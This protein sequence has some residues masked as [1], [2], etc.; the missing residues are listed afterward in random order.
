MDAHPNLAYST[1]AVAP[2]PAVSGTTLDVA[3]GDGALF[4]SFPFN[5]TVWPA[6][7]QPTVDN[8]EIVRITGRSTDTLTIDRAEEGTVART[9]V[10]GD[11]IAVTITAKTLTD[12]E[13]NNESVVLH[14]QL[15]GV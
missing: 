14:A 9:I 13:P 8:A 5:A 6:G 3:S 12:V 2:S 11:Q 7:E 1:V 10:V 15:L 4:A